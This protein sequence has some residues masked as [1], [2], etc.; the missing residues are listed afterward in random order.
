MCIF[1][2]PC[3]CGLYANPAMCKLQSQR[4]IRRLFDLLSAKGGNDVIKCKR[5]RIVLLRVEAG[6]RKPHML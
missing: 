5:D 3:F 4:V 1:L 2:S 6:Q